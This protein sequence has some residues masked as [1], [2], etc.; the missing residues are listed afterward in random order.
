MEYLTPETYLVRFG[1]VETDRI[2]RENQNDA[3]AARVKLQTAITDAQ[4]FANGY[5]AAKYSLPLPSVPSV[6]VRAV[7]D[8]AR[9]NL[10][11]QQPPQAVK[12]KADLARK[13]L[14]DIAA[15]RMKL[16]VE[17]GDTP[18]TAKA[19]FAGRTSGDARRPTFTDES[20][21]DFA[22]LGGPRC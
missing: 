21:A 1:P 12:D 15:G 16:P 8:L 18:P 20:L 17:D 11:P 5:V 7:A 9:E 3:A 6:L 19:G 22:S 4:D 10:F 13:L 14:A 2:T